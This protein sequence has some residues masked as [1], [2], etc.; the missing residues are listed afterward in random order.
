MLAV[1]DQR[2]LTDG[3]IIVFSSDHGLTIG[4]HGLLGKQN[5]YECSMG[6]PL[7]LTGPGVPKA[8]CCDA[9]CYLLDLFPTLCD[10]T[11]VELK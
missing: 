3:T 5:L 2:G 6:T 10:L 9:F 7:V 11:G 1:L 8:R 4:S